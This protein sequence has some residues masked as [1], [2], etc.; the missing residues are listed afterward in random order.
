MGFLHPLNFGLIFLCLQVYDGG[1]QEHALGGW[2]ALRDGSRGSSLERARC[3]DQDL[4]FLCAP[5]LRVD[6]GVLVYPLEMDFE[7]KFI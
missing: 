7:F 1:E 5:K 4:R 2:H 3:W 6:T